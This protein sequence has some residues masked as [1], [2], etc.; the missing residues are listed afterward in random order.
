V[1]LTLAYC[2]A[3]SV[4]AP[5]DRAELAGGSRATIAWVAE[6]PLPA[7]I[8]EWE[9]F[10]SVD[11][12]RYYAMRITPHLDRG[13]QRFT[14]DVPNVTS[15]DARIL[16]RFG[17]ERRETEVVLPLRLRIRHE[18]IAPRLFPTV[19]EEA[20]EAAREDDPPVAAWIAGSRDGLDARGVVHRDAAL[21]PRTFVG[22]TLLPLEDA[23]VP[24]NDVVHFPASAL[25]TFVCLHRRVAARDVPTHD[26][27]PLLE[28][29][30]LNI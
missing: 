6:R 15:N 16:L 21:A 10:L 8:E 2:C 12:G 11:G 9:A 29:M 4:T 20:G 19:D 17:D 28:T 23:L 18:S 13:V 1:I 30:R 3:L 27:D 7:G 22:V 26:D 25:R 5:A 14:F 24:N